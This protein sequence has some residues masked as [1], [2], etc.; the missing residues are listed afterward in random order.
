[1]HIFLISNHKTNIHQ[2]AN[3]GSLHTD[4]GFYYTPAPPKVEWGYTGFIP[5][6]VHPSVRP[7]VHPSVC[8]QG[9]GNF[10]KKLLAQFISYLAFTLMGWVSWPLFIFVFLASFLAL[11]W[12][13]IWLK[14][15]FQKLFEKNNWPN[16]FHTWHSLLGGDFLNPYTFPCS[17]P[18]FPSSGGQIFGQKC[19]FRNFFGKT[20]GS[21]YFIPGIYTYRISF[22]TPIHFQVPSLIF[23]PLVG[24]QIFGRKWGFRN[25]LKKN[26]WLNSFHTWHSSLWGESL[27]PYTFSAWGE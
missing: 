11:W 21:I 9:F 3:F 18:H 10:F 17:Y 20:I 7:S 12:L 27:D 19:G 1:M 16:S 22:L 5:M 24:G 26:Y 13:N 8:R 23:G 14:M 15:G 6:S 4:P 2:N 25:F